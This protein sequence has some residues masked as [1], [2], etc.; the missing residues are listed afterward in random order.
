MVLIVEPEILLDGSHG[1]EK[2]LEVAEKVSSKVLYYLAKNNVV[3]EEILLKPSMVTPV[4][5]CPEM[6][7]L[8][9]IA[10]YILKFL[11]VSPPVPCIMV[12]FAN[13][14]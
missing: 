12:S 4:A 13:L 1:I 8:D 7:T 6:A 9:K 5:E 10:E 2:M 11:R 3:F 14:V